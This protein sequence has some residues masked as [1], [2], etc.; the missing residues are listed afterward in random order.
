MGSCGHGA[1]ST[2]PSSSGHSVDAKNKQFLE[3]LS[4]LAREGR[5]PLSEFLK[6]SGQT[7]EDDMRAMRAFLFDLYCQIYDIDPKTAEGSSVRFKFFQEL[8]KGQSIEEITNLFIGN[9]YLTEYKLKA[10]APEP[11]GDQRARGLGEQARQIIDQGYSRR[12]SLNSIANDLSVSKEHLSRVFKKKFAVTVTEYIHQVRIENAR[13]LMATGE[14]SLKQVCYETG[15]QSYNDFYRNFRKVT[16][17]SPKCF[18]EPG[19]AQATPA[20]A[21]HAGGP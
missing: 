18:V 10:R 2:F 20:S 9:L 11:A 6:I 4:G 5:R 1:R 7:G 19:D 12:I 13:R 14:Y 15:Y 3:R 16:G 8:S 21:F 17:V